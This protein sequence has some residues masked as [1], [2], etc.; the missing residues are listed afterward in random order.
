M[1]WSKTDPKLR[2][3]LLAN[4]DALDL[5][6]QGA[7]QADGI[8]H[9]VQEET[10]L[11]YKRV[12][13]KPIAWLVLLE[14]SR[15]E[16]QGDMAE[17]WTWY[18]A[19]LRMQA[20]VMR[21]GTVFERFFTTLC[22]NWLQKRV[23]IWAADPRTDI[24]HLRRALDDLIET[25]PR[26]EWDLT[27]LKIDYLLAMRELDR[28][29]SRIADEEDLKYH[30]GDEDLPPNLA[31][32]VYHARQFLLREPERSRRVLRLVFANWLAHI[33][34]PA[35][36]N[37]QSAVRASFRCM[38]RKTGVVFYA[39]GSSA[40]AGARTL[41]P[42]DLAEWLMKAHDAK[43]LLH[44]WPWPSISLQERR[45]HRVLLICLAEELYR[46]EHGGSPPSEEALVG[47]YLQSLP[48]D[49]AAE[50]D[51]GTAL[52]VEDTQASAPEAILK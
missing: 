18:R 11:H 35:E 49:G 39:A 42:Q 2:G 19:L 24:R 20:L 3:W 43:Q 4:R 27:S 29:G 8:A 44:Q 37:R 1:G 22:C 6:R 13:L 5:F 32:Q 40:P 10:A 15:L 30:I 31:L 23:A 21:R 45:E 46:R 28:P 50:L 16:E 41:P 38:G 34:N 25:G 7:E 47:T 51:D 14:G 33:E 12:N 17:A 48:D 36:R 9:P 26:R 52:I